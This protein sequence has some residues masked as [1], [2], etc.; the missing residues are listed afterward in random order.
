MAIRAKNAEVVQS[1]VISAPVD[2][3]EFKR[4]RLIVPRL[5]P[6]DLTPLLF[7]AR[8]E[9]PLLQIVRLGKASEN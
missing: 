9:E 5:K 6:T 8:V 7:E 3:I 1:V 2:M 4:D